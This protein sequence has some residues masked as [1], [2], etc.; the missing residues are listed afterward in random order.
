[1]T[2]KLFRNIVTIAA[3]AFP[4]VSLNTQIALA[5]RRDFTIQNNNELAIV[6]I[7]VSSGNSRYWGRNILEGS[8][9][10]SG[11]STEITFNNSSSQCIYDY[12]AVY[13]NDTYDVVGKANLCE[14]FTVNFYG[15]GGDYR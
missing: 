6:E 7:Y 4:S 2:L 10:P 13:E 12:K 5:D 15:D 11:G 1:M 14:T 9:L 8:I 3:L